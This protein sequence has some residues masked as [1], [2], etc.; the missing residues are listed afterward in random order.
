[1]KIRMETELVMSNRLLVL[2]R[3]LQRC[4]IVQILP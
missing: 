4:R 1:M 3:I 2:L